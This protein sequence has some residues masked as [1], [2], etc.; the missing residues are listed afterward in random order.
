MYEGADNFAWARQLEC[1]PAVCND[2]VKKMFVYYFFL[3][4]IYWNS[5]CSSSRLTFPFHFRLCKGVLELLWEDIS[6]SVFPAAEACKIRK[7]I[8]LY[9]LKHGLNDS[10]ILSVRDLNQLRAKSNAL[11]QQI[12]ALE[13]EYEEQDHTVRQKSKMTSMH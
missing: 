10:A 2:S 9:K 13:E 5:R 11:K 6:N 4:S 8:L 1:P 3:A 12:S 7:N